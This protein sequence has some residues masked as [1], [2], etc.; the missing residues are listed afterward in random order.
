MVADLLCANVLVHMNDL[1]KEKKNAIVNK[2]R[3]SKE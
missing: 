2:N 3:I 1:A